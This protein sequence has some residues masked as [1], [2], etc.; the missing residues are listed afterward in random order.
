MTRSGSLRQSHLAGT[1]RLSRVRNTKDVQVF[2][3]R[4]GSVSTSNEGVEQ[5]GQMLPRGQKLGRARACVDSDRC[6]DFDALWWCSLKD[7]MPDKHRG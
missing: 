5:V 2:L 6:F 4:E 3:E 7:H 1:A